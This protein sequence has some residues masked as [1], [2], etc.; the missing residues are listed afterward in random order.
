LYIENIAGRPIKVCQKSAPKEGVFMTPF[1][2]LCVQRLNEGYLLKPTQDSAVFVKISLSE[3]PPPDCLFVDEDSL[4]EF[5]GGV[6]VTHR[7][8]NADD[9]LVVKSW[10]DDYKE[11]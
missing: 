4:C 11:P 7:W 9:V 5:V 10:L 1:E 6:L 8:G 2:D 3:C